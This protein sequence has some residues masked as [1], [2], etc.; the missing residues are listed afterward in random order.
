MNDIRE[1][2]KACGDHVQ[3]D[4]NV[5]IHVP[6]CLSVGNYV[7]IMQGF[8]L[9]EQLRVGR[10]GDHV[11]IYPNVF[12]QGIGELIIDD[13][14]TLYP[15][16]YLSI[17][18]GEKSF[19]HIGHHSHCAPYAALYGHGGLEI[20]PYCNIAA[21]TVFATV[22]HNHHI[23]NCPM[24]Q[25]PGVIGPITLEQDIWIGANATI[26]ANTRIAQG[27]VIGANAVLTKDTQP[28]GVYMGVPAKR[29]KDR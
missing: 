14:V 5:T 24:A 13:H 8:H 2:L 9:H 22:G 23:V 6:H 1:E 15:G 27:C 26:L 10:I 3:I 21:H 19:I 12:I 20:G 18:R 28:R 16:V 4:P 25:A 29:V 7:N 11:T 17:G